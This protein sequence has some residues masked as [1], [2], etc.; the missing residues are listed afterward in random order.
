MRKKYET[1]DIEIIKLSLTDVILA[2]DA[3]GVGG[4][5]DN[6]GTGGFGGDGDDGL[7]F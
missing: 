1:P 5:G 2:S 6:G 7:G 3:E 4:G